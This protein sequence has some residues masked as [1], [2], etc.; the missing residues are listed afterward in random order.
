MQTSV[1]PSIA[2]IGSQALLSSV[3]SNSGPS[4]GTLTFTEAV[5]T[6][7]QIQSAS[8]DYGSC[9]V[10]GQT[11]TCTLNPAIGQNA[12]VD[13]VVTPTQAGSFAATASITNSA[14]LTDP[15]TANNAATANLVVDAL[16]RQ[17]IVPGLKKLPLAAAKML[18]GELGCTVHVKSKHTSI[19]K[20][21][22]IGTSA[23]VGTYPFHQLVTVTVSEGPR[24]NKRKHH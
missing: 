2:A 12:T 18:L 4:S 17:C 16:P 23:R 14:G 21:L 3:V 5:P 10:S 8:A 9:S 6:G 11:V 1:L 22:V 20:G 7:V 19:T 13:V 15:N 24:K